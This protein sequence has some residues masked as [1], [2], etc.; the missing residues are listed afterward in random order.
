MFT[1]IT[2]TEVGYTRF[3]HCKVILFP[4]FYTVAW[5]EISI[6]NCISFLSYNYALI[7]STLSHMHC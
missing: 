7:S 2:F 5:K 1:L 3:L 4:S 6:R